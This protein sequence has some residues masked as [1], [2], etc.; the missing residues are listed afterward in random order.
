MNKIRSTELLKFLQ[1]KGVLGGSDIDIKNA[2]QQYRAEYKRK[3]KQARLKIKPELRPNF[4]KKE[5][6]SISKAAKVRGLTSTNFVRQSALS[7]A[8]NKTLIPNQDKLLTILQKLSMAGIKISNKKGNP[9]YDTDV[10]EVDDLLQET[11]KLLMTYLG[12]DH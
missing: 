8:S 5:I 1:L 10:K 2:K 7:L 12:Y 4:T 11:E 6:E 3:W 9:F